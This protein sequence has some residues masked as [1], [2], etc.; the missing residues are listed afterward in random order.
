MIDA[1]VSAARPH[2][3]PARRRR[4]AGGRPRGVAFSAPQRPEAAQVLRAERGPA[5]ASRCSSSPRWTTPRCPA[6]IRRIN[7]ALALA[8]ARAIDIT[9]SAA[10][11]AGVQLARPGRAA[12]SS[13]AAP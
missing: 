1:I 8:G 9:I 3:A 10:D 13:E 5:T 6:R 4:H 7:A 11:L 2:A 12:R